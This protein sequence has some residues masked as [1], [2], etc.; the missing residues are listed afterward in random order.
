MRIA[1]WNIRSAVLAIIFSLAAGGCASSNTPGDPFEGF[2]RAMFS[3]NETVDTAVLEP[4]ATGYRNVV[5]EPVR[6]CTGN[7]FS[8]INDIFVAVNSLLQGKVGDAVSDACR[9]LINSTV[10]ILG[11][12]DVASKMGLEKHNRDFGQTFGKWGIASG[13]YLVLPFLGPSSI[14]EGVGTMI[15]SRLDPVWANHIPTRNVAYS[16]RAVNGRS[17]L[18]SASRALED[19]ALDKYAF[20]RDAYVQRRQS[21]IDDGEN[22]ARPR[23]ETSG[24]LPLAFKPAAAEGAGQSAPAAA[25]L[26]AAVWFDQANQRRGKLAEGAGMARKPVAAVRLASSLPAN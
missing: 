21:L 13:P 3:F 20:V 14:R 12:F 9:V 24:E 4:I 6:E 25:A 10:G 23:A 18:L 5:P 11:C 16:L 17:D 1:M 15:Y 8:N 2:N 7:V 19:A 22:K 26:P